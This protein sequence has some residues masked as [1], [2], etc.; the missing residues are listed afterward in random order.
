MH[1]HALDFRNGEFL[2]PREERQWKGH[3]HNSNGKEPGTFAQRLKEG[4]PANRV[5]SLSSRSIL[6]C[7]ALRCWGWGAGQHISALTASFPF[8]SANPG[9][10]R[11]TAGLNGGS[12]GRACC[13]R[14]GLRPS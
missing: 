7:S 12:G 9:Q 2:K 1:I 10:E 4:V 11:E 13:Q 6:F 14:A 8:G 3:P 5:P